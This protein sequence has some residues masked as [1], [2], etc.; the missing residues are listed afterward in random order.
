M[1]IRDRFF[2]STAISDDL[3]FFPD[4]VTAIAHTYLNKKQESDPE[5]P[6]VKGTDCKVSYIPKE[7]LLYAYSLDSNFLFFDD[8]DSDLMGELKLG[9]DGI[10]GQGIMR[11]GSG[12]VESYRYTY[13]TDA[14]LS[15]TSEFR[16]VSLN[17]ELDALSFKTQNLN[18]RVD[19]ETRIGEFKS[20]SGESFVTFPEN[21]YICYMDQFNWYM[22][23]DNL[24]MENSKQAEADINIDTDLDLATSNFF[25]INHW[26]LIGIISLYL[27]LA[28]FLLYFFKNDTKSKK[29]YFTFSSIFFCVTIISILT[30]LTKHE[31]QKSN[32]EAIIFDKKIDFRTEPNYRSEVQF[33]LHEGT[34]V[35]ICL[36]YTSPSPRD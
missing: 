17:N 35:L 36:L 20:N 3:T 23:N 26:I 31:N 21:Q 13:E 15:D 7:S 8:E 11:F 19:F 18:A 34:K 12:E 22:D 9:Y 5:I 10:I 30:G 24:E 16:L 14:I 33:N 1:C 27:S 25:S 6:L 32:I 29:K 2:T 28:L 4:S